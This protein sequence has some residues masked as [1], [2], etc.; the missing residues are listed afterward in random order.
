MWH[1]VGTGYLPYQGITPK[2][3]LTAIRRAR[4]EVRITTQRAPHDHKQCRRAVRLPSR[5]YHGARGDTRRT[6]YFRARTS[7]EDG[8]RI[9]GTGP[10]GRALLDSIR[11]L[12]EGLP[13][14]T[15]EVFISKSR[16]GVVACVLNIDQASP[17]ACT[18]RAAHDGQSI[19]R[20][21]WSMPGASSTRQR[22]RT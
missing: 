14:D 13:G 9:Y 17:F 2:L 5:P 18:A 6:T 3:N 8:V 19:R 12:H 4:I 20:W 22:S 16:N 1:N 21:S 11:T 10:R 7:M 15:I